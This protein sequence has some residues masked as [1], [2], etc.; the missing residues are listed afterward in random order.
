MG[1]SCEFLV[2]RA[3]KH[4]RAGRYDEA[5]TLLSKAK[6]QFGS[7]EEIEYEAA[8]VYEAIGCYDDARRAY[9]RVFSFHDE[10]EAEALYR[11]AL[12][13]ASQGDL[14]RAA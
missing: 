14:D 9:L 11:L 7:K 8:C 13:S 6:D 5:M 10:R 4:R 1:Q 12:L 3:A 2:A